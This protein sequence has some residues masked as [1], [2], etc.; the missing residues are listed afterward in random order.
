MKK[1]MPFECLD[2]DVCAEFLA[3]KH[4]LHIDFLKGWPEE[5][6][7]ELEIDNDEHIF[8][9]QDLD[10]SVFDSDDCMVHN[11]LMVEF[12]EDMHFIY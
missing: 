11:A 4:G 9:M 8:S 1:P 12:G 5:V 6:L 10:Q 3:S 7:L 2:W